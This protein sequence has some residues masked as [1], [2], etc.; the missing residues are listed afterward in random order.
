MINIFDLTAN[1]VLEEFADFSIFEGTPFSCPEADYWHIM[2]TTVPEK[3]SKRRIK[4]SIFIMCCRLSSE[5]IP[6]IRIVCC[7]GDKNIRE[8]IFYLEDFDEDNFSQTLKV[9]ILNYANRE[10]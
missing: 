3:I 7:Q 2:I 10:L 1:I 4:E 8:T 9:E 6:M 5:N